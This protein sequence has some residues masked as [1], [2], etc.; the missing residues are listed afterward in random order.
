MSVEQEA[1]KSEL[2]TDPA[3]RELLARVR[4]IN[5]DGLV[6][7]PETFALRLAALLA[8]MENPLAYLRPREVRLGVRYEF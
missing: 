6:E 3:E 7:Y 5:G 2:S 4:D 1:L 8:A